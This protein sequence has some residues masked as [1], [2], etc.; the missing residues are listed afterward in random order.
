L[1]LS[2]VPS[3]MIELLDDRNLAVVG[4][5]AALMLGCS[6]VV[7]LATPRLVPRTAQF[8]G[9]ALTTG[10]AGALVAAAELQSL[11]AI[12]LAGALAGAGLGCAFRGA[13]G[14]VIAIAPADAKGNMV[15]AFYI[16]VYLG[17]ALPVIGV[18]LLAQSSG[19]LD[20]VRAFD[21]AIGT[22]CALQLALV[23]RSVRARRA[24]G[25]RRRGGVR[26]DHR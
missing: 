9:I 8:V 22:A 3:Y 18:G 4:G 2:L 13:L 7:Q 19:L 20:A 15:A 10:A 14:A 25:D 1:F 21:Y 26:A 11:A 16:V 12:V 17:T 24:N 5:V 23:A 6:A